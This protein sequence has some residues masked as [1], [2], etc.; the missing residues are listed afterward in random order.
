[1]ANFGDYQFKIY[2]DGLSGVTPTLP[3]TYRDLEARAHAAMPPGLVS[4]VAGGCGDER[5]QDANAEAFGR[6]GLT[7]RMLVGAT[8]RD[9]SVDLFGMRLPSPVFMAPVGVIGLCAQDGHGDVATARAA[10]ATGR[11]DGRLHADDRPDGE[12]GAGVRAARRASSSSTPPP[13]A[14]WPRALCAAPRP[15][16]S[17]AS[18]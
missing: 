10:A 4:Y 2:F 3:M 7:P 18:W 1:M 6:W 12:G 16:G 8:E 5:T 14:R 17:R 9:L 11:A 13:I 15:P